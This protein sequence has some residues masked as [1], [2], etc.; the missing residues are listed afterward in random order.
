MAAEEAWTGPPSGA[1]SATRRRAEARR[2]QGGGTARDRRPAASQQGGSAVGPRHG[3][4][5]GSRGAPAALTTGAAPIAS[6]RPGAAARTRFPAKPDTPRSSEPTLLP[7][8][9][10]RVADF[11]Y[12]HYSID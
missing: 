4:E 10:I 11:P 2:R 7:K 6:P 3:T 1:P 5:L 9:R 12:L 8:V